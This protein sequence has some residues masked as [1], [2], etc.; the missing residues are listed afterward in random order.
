MDCKGKNVV[1]EIINAIDPECGCFTM[2][3]QLFYNKVARILISGYLEDHL[4]VDI[5]SSNRISKKN[6][7]DYLKGR[8]VLL[9][10]VAGIKRRSES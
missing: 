3:E 5:L 8:R 1:E 10:M 9:D 2:E 4:F 6:T 7:G